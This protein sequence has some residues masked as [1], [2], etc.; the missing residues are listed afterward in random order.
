MGWAKQGLPK[1]ILINYRYTNTVHGSLN[2]RQILYIGSLNYRHHIIGVC[3]GVHTLT[4]LT[5]IRLDIFKGLQNLTCTHGGE[6]VYIKLHFRISGKIRFNNMQCCSPQHFAGP[7]TRDG[8]MFTKEMTAFFSE[9]Y[10]FY[11]QLESIP[12]TSGNS[13][14]C[15]FFPFVRF[16]PMLVLQGFTSHLNNNGLREKEILFIIFMIMSK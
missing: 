14:D 5:C 2:Y 3:T 4:L 6:L 15:T 1:A 10:R 16:F 7:F 12:S 11:L 13:S 8:K 9:L